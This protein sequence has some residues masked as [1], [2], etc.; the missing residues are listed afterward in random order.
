MGNHELLLQ[1]GFSDLLLG[2]HRTE[3]LDQSASGERTRRR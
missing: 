3:T 1:T 2:L